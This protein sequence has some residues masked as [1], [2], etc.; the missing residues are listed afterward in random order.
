MRA[1][2]DLHI[3]SALS[4]CAG[5]E[6]TPNNIVG[7]AALKGLDFIAV[8]D[9]NAADNLPAV[10]KLCARHKIG[11]I[12]GMEVQTRE[13]V[14]VLC[15]FRSVEDAL[16]IAEKIRRGLPDIQMRPELFGSQLVLDEEDRLVGA[17][18]KMLIQSSHWSIEELY[19]QVTALGGAVVPAHINRGAFSLLYMLG[20]LPESPKFA[21]LE[22]VRGL[23]VTAP[24]PENTLILHSSD[25]HSLGAILEQEFFLDLQEKS[26]EA[27]LSRLKGETLS[28]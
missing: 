20:F 15:Y 3:H 21:A 6:M 5:D 1:A 22:I 9:H 2:C 4:P 17:V 7:M 28:G 16:L 13:E 8:T 25:A 24:I 26:S 10:E 11:F 23:P 14:H 27:L 12:P 18:E 19:A